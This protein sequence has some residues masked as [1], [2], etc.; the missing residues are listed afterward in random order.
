MYIPSSP[1]YNPVPAYQGG[2]Q[3]PSRPAQP[4]FQGGGVSPL[5]DSDSEM[6]ATPQQNNNQQQ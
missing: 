5:S 3:Q 6:A 4:A 1:C 2:S